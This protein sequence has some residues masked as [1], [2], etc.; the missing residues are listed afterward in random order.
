M[1]SGK[2]NEEIKLRVTTQEKKQIRKLS[3]SSKN[4]T[5]YIL[6]KIFAPDSDHHKSIAK[7]VETLDLV[8][9]IMLEVEKSAD[10]LL[11]QKIKNIIAERM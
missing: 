11:K 3:S 1:N 8:N 10:E 5:A 7:E 9:T 4:M 2:K 6:D